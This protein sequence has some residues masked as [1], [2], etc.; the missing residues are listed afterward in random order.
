M[1]RA[2]FPLVS[3]A[4]GR[5]LAL[6][7]VGVAAGCAEATVGVASASEDS[8]EPLA[9]MTARDG[10]AGAREDPSQPRAA[11]TATNA[12][13]PSGSPEGAAAVTALRQYPGRDA[14]RLVL[15]LSR[16]VRFRREPSP[17]GQLVLRLTATATPSTPP[18]F[19]A[20]ALAQGFAARADGADTLLT[21]RHAP[22]L[23][24]HVFESSEP[25]RLVVDLV[26]RK[27]APAADERRVRRV[28][29]DPGHGG[30]D[31][32]ALAEGGL[33]EKDVVLDIAQRAAG[34][35]ARELGVT[36]LLTRDADVF[37]PLEE[38]TARANAFS[39][40]L[41]VSVHCNASQLASTRGVAV[42][43]LD[44]A[45]HDGATGLAARE[46]AS[47]AEAAHALGRSAAG[48]LGAETL[49]ASAHFAELLQRAAGASL[50]ARYAD[51][52]LLGV[53]RAGFF[54]LAGARMPAALYETSFVSNPRDGAYLATEDYRQKLADS[55]VNAVR[56]YRD[57][58]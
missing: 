29:L 30:H 12:P 52:P 58:Y 19:R 15:V 21:L 38:R 13:E 18:A 4:A 49:G 6:L 31:P 47:S 27:S 51:V 28:V 45:R 57:G 35:L 24:A 43:V 10:V 8:R 5:W 56:A 36:T 23:D 40:D 3:A 7:G 1:R 2:R 50:A 22:A 41:F 37:I 11:T 54:V 16:A 17:A 48:L 46:N 25:P 53:E 14:E 33:A 34:L 42:Y 39:A 55:V 32:G 44:G 26:R 9:A 20:D